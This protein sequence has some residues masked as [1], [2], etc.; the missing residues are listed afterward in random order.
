[1]DGDMTGTD[2]QEPGEAQ[3]YQIRIKGIVDARWS[4]WFEGLSLKPLPCGEI[5]LTGPVVDQA[6]LHGILD[7]IYGL[8]LPLI[9]VCRVSSCGLGGALNNELE[10]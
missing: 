4:E 8:N 7:R 5:L 1:M 10:D 9:S 6:A 2:D 3:I